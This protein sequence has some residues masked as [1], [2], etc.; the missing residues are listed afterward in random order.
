MDK[1]VPPSF[2][3][4]PFYKKGAHISIHPSHTFLERQWAHP[5]SEDITMLTKPWQ[6][7]ATEAIRILVDSFESNQATYKVYFKEGKAKEIAHE[8]NVMKA[9]M[10]QALFWLNGQNVDLI[11]LKQAISSFAYTPLNTQDR[12]VFI[13]SHQNDRAFVQLCSFMDDLKKLNERV[14]LLKRGSQL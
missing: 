5:F 9:M 2:C 1:I 3:V 10:V 13:L 11:N 7:G 6:T 12:L 8:Q 14:N 4:Q